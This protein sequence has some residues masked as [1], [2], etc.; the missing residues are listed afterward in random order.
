MMKVRF[1]FKKKKKIKNKKSNH[2]L[3]HRLFV[4]QGK[5]SGAVKERKLTRINRP[6]VENELPPLQFE[7]EE[8]ED[9]DTFKNSIPER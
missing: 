3:N 7:D 9:D 8:E 1:V 2:H 6:I 5:M 4:L